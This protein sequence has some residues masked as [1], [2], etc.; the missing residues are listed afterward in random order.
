MRLLW[1]RFS[2]RYLIS[3]LL[4]GWLFNF[5]PAVVVLATFSCEKLVSQQLS[6]SVANNIVALL[7]PTILYSIRLVYI[8][9]NYIW[10]KEEANSGFPSLFPVNITPTSLPTFLPTICTKPVLRNE[11]ADLSF[12]RSLI[13][14]CSSAHFGCDE[15]FHVIVFPLNE[16]HHGLNNIR[17]GTVKTKFK[18]KTSWLVWKFLHSE[19]VR[20][21]FLSLWCI[22]NDR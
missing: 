1:K 6:H 18:V 19:N 10:T 3:R 11:K 2:G 15:T 14:Y 20:L 12:A 13:F 9:R 17:N 8:I 7:S 22:D 21:S 5:C 16:R 4:K